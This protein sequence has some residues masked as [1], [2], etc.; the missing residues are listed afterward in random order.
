MP[1][2]VIVLTSWDYTV[3]AP[4]PIISLKLGVRS[5]LIDMLNELSSRNAIDPLLLR[6]LRIRRLIGWLMWSGILA[7]SFTV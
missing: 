2:G 5:A 7:G 3:T 6:K 4:A 1:F